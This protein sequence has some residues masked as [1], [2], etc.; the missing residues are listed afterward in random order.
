MNP[1]IRTLL[2]GVA[3]SLVAPVVTKRFGGRGL[4]LLTTL[5]TLGLATLLPLDR[6]ERAAQLGFA[7]PLIL[8]PLGTAYVIWRL[9]NRPT[10]PSY[11]AQFVFGVGAFLVVVFLLL[12]VV[13][14]LVFGGYRG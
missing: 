4:V 8:G 5:A 9:A 3:Y 11:L 14:W 2:F 7:L 1:F 10:P 6:L 13:F 12:F